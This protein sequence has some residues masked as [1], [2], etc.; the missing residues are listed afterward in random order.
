MHV[1]LCYVAICK[2]RMHVV[3]CFYS[4]RVLFFYRPEGG[5]L[6]GGE[7]VSREGRWWGDGVQGQHSAGWSLSKGLVSLYTDKAGS[8][9]PGSLIDEESFASISSPR[10][11]PPTV[12]T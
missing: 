3:S 9:R 12:S 1:V 2:H 11:S 8:G 6:G 5:L 4:G 7:G 10:A